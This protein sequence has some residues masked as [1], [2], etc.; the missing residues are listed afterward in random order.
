MSGTSVTKSGDDA[1]HEQQLESVIADFIRA[2]D[3]GEVPDRQPILERHPDLADELR[4]FFAQRDRMN[5]FAEPI[6]GFGDDLFRTV[7][8]GK[9]IS[10][11]GDYELLEEVARGGM[12]VVYKA[13]QKALRRIVAVKMMLTGQLANEEDVKRFQIEA[14][15][16]ASLQHPNIVSIH[17]VGL[18]EGLHYFSMDFVEGRNLSAV[19]RENLLPA[20]QA[21]TYVRQMAEAIHYAHQQG[22]LHRDL[23]P[24]NVLIDSHD[25]VH[26]TDFGLAM[27]VEGDSELTR[28]GQIVGTPS[29]M[30]PEQARGQRSQIGPVSD[31]YSL[32]AILYECLTGKPPFRA[33]SV[34]ETIQQVIHVEAPSPRLLNPAVPRDLETICLKCLEKEPHRRYET[35]QLLADD[36]KHF[37]L[38][39]P[40]SAR[41]ISRPARS[42]RWCKRNPLVAGLSAA[43]IVLLAGTA[44]VTTLG[45]FRESKLRDEADLASGKMEQSLRELKDEQGLSSQLRTDVSDLETRREELNTSL[46]LGETKLGLG[47]EKLLETYLQLARAAW[48]SENIE[49]ADYY[50]NQCPNHLR[51]RAWHDLKHRCYPNLVT[52]GGQR[53]LALSDDGKLLATVAEKTVQVWDVATQ[54]LLHT[55][56]PDIGSVNAIDIS[57]DGK[58]LAIGGGSRVTLWNLAEGTLWRTLEGHQYEVTDVEF[59]PDGKELASASAT[60][61]KSGMTVMWNGEAFVW[62]LETSQRMLS[63][64]GL[65][66]VVFS[67]DG[68]FL[69]TSRTRV[70]KDYCYEGLVVWDRSAELDEKQDPWLV[71]A[72]ATAGC[73]PAFHPFRNELAASN[74]RAVGF[75]D[76]D[77][78][79]VLSR[80]TRGLAVG[81]LAYSFD[82]KRLAYAGQTAGH[83]YRPYAFQTVIWNLIT[84]ENERT[85]PWYSS[86]ITKI[87]FSLD[88]RQLATAEVQGIKLWDVTPP[89]DPTAA[90]LNDIVELKVGQFDWPQWG[91]SRAR[92]NTPSGKNIP[93]TWTVGE[94][95]WVRYQEEDATYQ[96]H[97]SWKNGEPPKDSKN[98]KWAVALGSE[99]YGNPVVA[100][101]KVFL[102]TNNG[103]GYLKRYPSRVDLGVL[104]C[105]EEATGK[106]LWQH[107]NEKLPTGRVHDWPNQGVCSTPVVDGDRLWYVS[108]R[109][110]VVCLDTEGFLDGENDGP[111]TSE[112]P[113][114]PDVVWDEQHEADVVW[115][116]NMMKELGVSQHNMA[117]CSM[118]TAD[119]MLFVCTS[120][121][122][123][124]THTNIPAPEAPSFLA[125]DRDTGKVIWTDNSPGK[126]ILHAQWGSPSYGVFDGSR[127]VIFAGG[128]GWLYS[129]DPQG[130]GQGGSK[131][132]WKFDGNPKTSQYHLGGR[133]T[134]NHIIAFPAIYD[135]LIYLVMG[136]DPEHGEGVGHLWCIDPTKRIDGSDVSAE[137]AVD[138]AGQVIPH[139]R[140]QAVDLAKGEK[141]LPNPKSAVVW[142]Y[143]YQ[144][145][146]GDG[147]IKFEEQFHRSL[148]IPV[149]KD[150]VLYVADF[151]GLFHCLNAKT[152]KVYWTYDQ[153]A[154]CWGSAL[155][156]D[157]KVYICDE[158]GDVTVFRHSADPRIAMKPV[159]KKDGRTEFVPIN[160]GWD[161]DELSV[162]NMGTA[163]YM[164]PIVANNVLF[165]ATR[166]TLYAIQEM[167]ERETPKSDLPDAA[168]PQNLKSIP[169]EPPS[170]PTSK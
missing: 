14:H 60:A 128:D 118:L 138:Q 45:Y 35:A 120:N 15:A 142:H 50:L 79:Q 12:G 19:L 114:K 30:P 159:Q 83:D 151:S 97:P 112:K 134:R 170:E 66:H 77:S 61:S 41:P 82:G 129:F 92:I 2:C 88:G 164:T 122:V 152:G 20:K 42:W 154:A 93:I 149:I 31:V 160:A 124:D 115:K 55:L 25:Q 32:G 81:C 68:R 39:E 21:A 148:S 103:Q 156:V 98:I 94:G 26:I 102:G 3:A 59:S 131:L 121:G 73:R 147:T 6:R 125:M 116:F 166:N 8:P 117:N 40:I 165:I 18:H 139:R 155:L 99:A 70:V 95:Q 100:N 113:G 78:K 72:G 53:C 10:Y 86:G 145:Q 74:G 44:A 64:P 146:D 58:L 54:R 132:L 51:K 141:A 140:L 123:D 23:K 69:A 105:F 89:P 158:D 33:D 17:E 127:Q 38:G 96:R 163:V 169:V 119:G 135:G 80:S 104:L 109:G 56:Q 47:E 110:E 90:I 144:D 52:F 7:G 11:V 126:N 136:E 161:S 143:S 46:E 29:Y 57:P 101:G 5:Q 37:L 62:N 1:E 107:S 27:R 85:L 76:V 36:L 137:L 9:H 63:L 130:D 16:A 111:F 108:N 133:S 150:D 168:K 106:F 157:G 91:G 22:T 43:T 84:L 4:D 162:C 13:Q 75:W 71:V 67:F 24:S 65:R 48:R 28:T 49:L 34:V 87:S 153:L 167:P